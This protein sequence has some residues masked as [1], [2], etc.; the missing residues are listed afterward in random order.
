MAASA[1]SGAASPIRA[2]APPIGA[3]TMKLTERLPQNT[4]NVRALVA[5]GTTFSR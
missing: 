5:S 4:L 1:H 3:P 2:S